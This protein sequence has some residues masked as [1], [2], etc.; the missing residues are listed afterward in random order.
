MN[1][2]IIDIYLS[3]ENINS[4]F[5][6]EELKKVTKN[7]KEIYQNN[8]TKNLNLYESLFFNNDE[9]VIYKLKN[10]LNFFYKK[11]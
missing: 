4:Y 8:L 1:K 10:S 3:D 2:N 11:L 9:Q 5:N 6:I 7:S